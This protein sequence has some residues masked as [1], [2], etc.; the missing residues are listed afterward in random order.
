MTATSRRVWSC[1]LALLSGYSVYQ[2]K[3]RAGTRT[4]S[5]CALL[6]YLWFLDNVGRAQCGSTESG[7]F[8]R[9]TQR[10]EHTH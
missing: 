7:R 3:W 5:H 2:N 1:S 8:D 4:P 10:V 6:C 9:A